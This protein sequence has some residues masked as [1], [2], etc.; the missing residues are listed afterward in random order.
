LIIPCIFSIHCNKNYNNSLKTFIS[1]HYKYAYNLSENLDRSYNILDFKIRD[2][3]INAFASKSNAFYFIVVSL[4]DSTIK[5][6]TKSPIKDYYLEMAHNKDKILFTKQPNGN[7]LYTLNYQG[8]IIKRE[9][10]GIEG[11]ASSEIILFNNKIFAPNTLAGN[12]GIIDLDKSKNLILNGKGG[13]CSG[14]ISYPLDTNL[15]LIMGHN[16]QDG[17][18]SYFAV[19]SNNEIIWE[20]LLNGECN[21]QNPYT[22][23]NLTNSFLICMND[24]LILLNKEDGSIIWERKFNFFIDKLFMN[25]DDIILFSRGER[26]NYMN[27]NNDFKCNS[28]IISFNLNRQKVNWTYKFDQFGTEC[29]SLSKDNILVRDG[30]SWRQISLSNGFLQ[31]EKI[32]NQKDRDENPSGFRTIIDKIT[33][34]SY[35]VFEDDDG[36]VFYWN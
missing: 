3:E 9:S 1:R 8:N 34:K 12:F 20:T 17:K 30:K 2:G 10:F 15:N 28:Q 29:I 22:L 21:E 11:M 31:N 5:A 7:I 16:P 13:F 36:M 26:R 33:G 6:I 23:L 19:N 35:I 18:V 4:K 32:L 14:N 25:N 27:W 24:T